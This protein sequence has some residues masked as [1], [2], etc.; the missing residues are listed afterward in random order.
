MFESMTIREDSQNPYLQSFSLSFIAWKEAF[1]RESPYQNPIDRAVQRGHVPPALGMTPD[2]S[3]TNWSDGTVSATVVDNVV[4]F[5][6]RPP[7]NI[8]P[9]AST[10]NTLYPLLSL[11]GWGQL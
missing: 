6:H 5:S 3:A 10:L 8:D 9:E 4:D 2:A 7:P 1:W 11:K